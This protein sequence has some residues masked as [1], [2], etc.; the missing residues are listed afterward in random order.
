MQPNS[1]LVT[2]QMV[3]NLLR[4]IRNNIPLNIL[5]H[6]VN[7][8]GQPRAID[9]DNL[10]PRLSILFNLPIPNRGSNMKLKFIHH[11]CGHVNDVHITVRNFPFGS[12][13]MSHLPKKVEQTRLR[14]E[15]PI[16]F[17]GIFSQMIRPRVFIFFNALDRI[18]FLSYIV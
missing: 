4:L 17:A 8:V 1:K 2:S 6:S 16:R 9:D 18:L 12:E 5:H 3:D 7:V 15:V 13:V 11:P 14:H 10:E